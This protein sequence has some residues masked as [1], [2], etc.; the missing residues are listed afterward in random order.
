MCPRKPS[1]RQI[2][3]SYFAV[4]PYGGLPLSPRAARTVSQ[5]VCPTRLHTDADGNSAWRLCSVA[6]P[7]LLFRVLN[8]KGE[9]NM[10]QIQV[11]LDLMTLPHGYECSAWFLNT[12]DT[13][14][15][16]FF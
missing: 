14:I 3:S 7:P 6:A 16:N 8:E 9:R 13:V 2:K 12:V 10:L 11:Q 1:G 4:V 5:A 15:F